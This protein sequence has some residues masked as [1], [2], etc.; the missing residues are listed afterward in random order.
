MPV[1][2]SPVRTRQDRRLFLELAWSL[3]H[4]D[5]CWVPPIREQIKEL[6][7]FRHHPFDEIGEVQPFLARRDGQVVGRIVAIVNRKHNE[8]HGER[9][10]FFGFFEAIDDQQVADALFDAASRWLADRGLFQVRGPLNPSINYEVGLLVAG[11]DSPPT[12]M[13]TY[14]P[15]YYARLIEG[16]GFRKTHDVYAYQG[17]VAQL[18]EVQARLGGMAENVLEHLGAIIRPMNRS[19]FQQEVEMFLDLYNRSFVQMWGAVPMT[20]GEVRHSATGLKHLLVP[21]MAMLAEID[22][23]PAGCV[24]GLPDYNPAIR[25]ADGR[26]FPDGIFR[27]LA[28]KR[29]PK[30]IRVLSINVVPEYQRWGLGLALMASLVPAA[31]R[32]GVQEAEFSWVSETNLLARQGLEKGGATIAKTYRVYDLDR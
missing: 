9:R 18:P 10:G 32:Y 11:F 8:V 30:R 21:E 20:P 31:L 27:M 3:Y 25:R 28:V 14:N 15:P 7:G 16:A 13:M 26:L 22:G 12:F 23:R 2:V 17:L 6:V 24:F 4:Y 1:V 29:H 5:P 19:R